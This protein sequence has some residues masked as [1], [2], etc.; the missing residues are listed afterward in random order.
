MSSASLHDDLADGFSYEVY[1]KPTAAVTSIYTGVLDYE[2]SGGFGLNLYPGS[3]A[4]TVK[5]HAEIAVKNGSGRMWIELV[6]EIPVNEWCHC[7]FSYN[8]SDSI[9]LYVN[10][11]RV[12]DTIVD[13]E[14]YEGEYTLTTPMKMPDFGSK[15]PY[16]CI[17]ACT[18]ARTG[19]TMGMEGSIAI[20]NIYS[21]PTLA[22]IAEQMYQAAVSK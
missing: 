16:I 9:S 11:E 17:G 8:G 4:S 6:A 10:G 5:L 14:P 22:S 20:C 2:E 7:V 19:T 18:A 12:T 21:T 13:E 15:T 3:S 1:F